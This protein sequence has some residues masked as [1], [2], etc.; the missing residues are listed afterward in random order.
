MRGTPNDSVGML[1]G[2]S[3]GKDVQGEIVSTGML[4][5]L[6]PP[7]SIRSGS[8]IM[9]EGMARKIENAGVPCSSVELLPDRWGRVLVSPRFSCLRGRGRVVKYGPA[10]WSLGRVYRGI[11]KSDVVWMLGVAWPGDRRC[12]FERLVR[13]AAGGYIF[14]LVDD[15]F[16]VD[17]MAEHAHC[18]VKAAD[19]VVVVTPALRRRVLEFHPQK[20][21]EVVEEP[22][23]IERLRSG[24]SR[25]ME[26]R[27][28]VVWTGS[29]YGLGD[30]EGVLPLLEEVFDV[31]P[32]TLR[33]IC[34]H[35]RPSIHYS[36]SW[37]WY[38]FDMSR[39][40][41]YL[42]GAAFGL[43]PLANTAYAQCKNTYKVKAYAGASLAVLASDI[44]YNKE[45]VVEG[46]TGY[47]LRRPDDWKQALTILLRDD[48]LTAKM[49]H[50]AF[51]LAL[52][53]FSQ[54]AVAPQWASVARR[55]FGL[56]GLE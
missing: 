41:D 53:R 16:S 1:G 36:R 8:D 52:R 39:E 3:V 27:P 40:A 10:L 6:H 5:L 54:E 14:H 22:V 56:G 33:V 49:G 2:G 48:D 46:T 31:V 28:V 4:K 13:R 50:A 47:L 19:V 25:Q 23:D 12:W 34:G 7:D 42:A 21:V 11:E 32:F 24:R 15:W 38:P 35:Q 55:H 37:E 30:L 9:C 29:P 17:S 44:G 43:A 18:R 51:D 45:L 26:G 20:L